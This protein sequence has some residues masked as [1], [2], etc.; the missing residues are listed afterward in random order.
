MPDILG[1]RDWTTLLGRIQE[2]KCTPFIG[3]SA[4]VPTLPLGA[5]VARGWA[6]E[7]INLA[8]M[9]FDEGLVCSTPS[10]PGS[11][12]TKTKLSL[13]SRR[14]VQTGSSASRSSPSDSPLGTSPTPPARFHTP[15]PASDVE[16]AGGRGAYGQSHLYC[17]LR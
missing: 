14:G 7:H 13:N 15:R 3:P 9:G 6:V 1:E 4:C 17:A 11:P 8:V 12:C 10:M 5:D 2:K 16:H